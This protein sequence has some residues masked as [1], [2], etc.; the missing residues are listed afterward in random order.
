VRVACMMLKVWFRHCTLPKW[1]QFAWDQTSDRWAW[2][3]I[4]GCHMLFES[5]K[6]E[7]KQQ[8]S[9]AAWRKDLCENHCQITVTSWCFADSFI[10]I[11]WF[12][13]F[14]RVVAMVNLSCSV[15]WPPMMLP[16]LSKWQGMQGRHNCCPFVL[17]RSLETLKQWQI[18][19]PDRWS[20]P[21]AHKIQ[22][23]LPQVQSERD[24]TSCWGN[25]CQKELVW[26][27]WMKCACPIMWKWV[28]QAARFWRLWE[29]VTLLQSWLK[30]VEMCLSWKCSIGFPWMRLKTVE[31]WNSS[32]DLIANHFLSS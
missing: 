1:V 14:V 22:W 21:A 27:W 2:I 16:S 20:N 24:N 13:W 19:P 8:G 5:K 10:S 17:T 7:G 15:G 32:I 3:K 6:M 12:I 25:F 30:T 28:W 9:F 31:K 29:F 11:F 23:P 4:C 18:R 26:I